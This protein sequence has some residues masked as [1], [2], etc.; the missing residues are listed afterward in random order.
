MR[1]VSIV[2]QILEFDARF[3]SKIFEPFLVVNAG[4][5]TNL[6][7]MCFLLSSP[8]YVVGCKADC[9]FT[10]TIIAREIATKGIA[11]AIT[12]DDNIKRFLVEFFSH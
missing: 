2:D 9:Q 5:S 10:A 1:L 3:F 8:I 11:T 12:A 6:G 4:Y 7:T